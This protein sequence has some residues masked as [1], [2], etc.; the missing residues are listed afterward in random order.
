MKR[1]NHGFTLLETLV[2]LAILAIALVAA[3][4]S[5]G[6]T[7]L[8]T[9]GLRERAL[10]DWVAQD[11]LAEYRA[12]AAFPAPGR[13]EGRARQGRSDFVWRETISGTPNALFRRIEV[14]VFDGTGGEQ[15][16]SATGFVSRPLR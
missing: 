7:A 15:L 14:R 11:R 9:A 4:R 12:S 10:A 2:A 3:L 1:S 16:S 6:N 13:N 5:V 8:A